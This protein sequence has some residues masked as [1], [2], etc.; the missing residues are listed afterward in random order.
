MFVLDVGGLFAKARARSPP[1]QKMK[2]SVMKTVMRIVK[3]GSE[4]NKGG[5]EAAV[6]AKPRLTT[7]MVVKS[8]IIDSRERRRETMSQLQSSIGWKGLGGVARG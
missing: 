1:T 4:V 7:E 6:P 8:W 3:R 5:G 2:V